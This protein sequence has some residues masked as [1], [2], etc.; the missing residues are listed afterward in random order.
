M[1]QRIGSF[2]DFI[3]EAQF[4]LVIDDIKTIPLTTFT[5]G[6]QAY[7]KERLELSNAD[8]EVYF[9][10]SSKDSIKNYN[11]MA[12]MFG[13]KPYQG[14]KH[15]QNATGQADTFTVF[16]GNNNI[17]IIKWFRQFPHHTK[18]DFWDAYLFKDMSAV[19]NS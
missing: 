4:Q 14:Q 11:A 2:E 12:Y 15:I 17:P 6:Q 5:E 8:K 1:K 7:I 13:K 9:V 19:Q 10:P 18:V 16:P 3:N